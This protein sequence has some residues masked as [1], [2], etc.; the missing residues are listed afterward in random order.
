VAANLRGWLLRGAGLLD[1]AGE[2]HELA[3]GSDSGP[4]FQEARYA[5]LLDLAECHLAAGHFDQGVAAVGAARSVLDW[6]GSM[7]WRHRNRY[8]LLADRVAALGGTYA[9]AA[10]DARAVARGAESRGDLR[11]GYRGLLVAATIEARSGAHGDL[12]TIGQL[13]ERFVPLC[14]PDG[15]RDLAELAAAT[16]SIEIWRRAE[17]QASAIVAEAGTRPRIDGDQVAAAVRRQLD[18]LKP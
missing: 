6:T 13:V 3:A 8:R 2:L 11:Y 1:E 16:G 4:T 5:G 12:E 10:G 18:R 17:R 15:W 9:D 7:S 14:G